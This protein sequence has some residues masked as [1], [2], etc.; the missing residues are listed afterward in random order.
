MNNEKHSSLIKETEIRLEHSLNIIKTVDSCNAI[1][2]LVG[3]KRIPEFTGTI[4]Y[5]K[6]KVINVEEKTKNK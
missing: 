1:L 2:E 4:T 5:E 3:A 6:G